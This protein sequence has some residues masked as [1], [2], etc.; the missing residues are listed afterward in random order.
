MP[1][2]TFENIKS[3]EVVTAKLQSSASDV[4]VSYLPVPLSDDNFK[5]EEEKLAME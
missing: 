4:G 1:V 5:H 2:T 3:N